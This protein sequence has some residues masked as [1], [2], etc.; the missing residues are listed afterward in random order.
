MRKAKKQVLPV[1]VSALAIVALAVTPALAKDS[2]TKKPSHS[3][4]KIAAESVGHAPE[5]P[6]APKAGQFDSAPGPAWKTL[7][8]T[9]K[10]VEGNIYTVEDYEGN[11][12]K[13]LVGQGTK[14]LQKKKVGDTVRAEITRGGFANSIQ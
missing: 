5:Q 12:V 14:K 10:K 1:L 13:L 7:G 8:G 2:K 6:E 4:A 11:H 3:S 9:L